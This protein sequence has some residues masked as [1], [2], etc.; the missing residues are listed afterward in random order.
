MVEDNWLDFKSDYQYVEASGGLVK[1]LE[2]EF[3]FIFKNGKWDLPKG[4]I[5][6]GE[7]CVDCAIREI[8]EEC[9]I[10]TLKMINKITDTYHVY[11]LNGDSFLKK[12]SWYYIEC[13]IRITPVP[14]VDEGIIHAKWI[15]TSKLDLILKSSYPNIVDV[16]RCFTQM[17]EC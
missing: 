11:K 2:S 10:H 4:K 9:G 1:N 17:N 16:Y 12:T 3:L 14:Q 6:N 7:D 8:T 15:S 5:E 13:G